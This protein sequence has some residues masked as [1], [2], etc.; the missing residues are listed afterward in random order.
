MAR[1]DEGD[2][3]VMM[4]HASHLWPFSGLVGV[5][6]LALLF[7]ANGYLSGGLMHRSGICRTCHPKTS[8]RGV[9]EKKADIE[10]IGAPKKS[11]CSPQQEVERADRVIRSL[12]N[13][14]FSKSSEPPF[15]I[16]QQALQTIALS[17][18]LLV[19]VRR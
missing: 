2:Y 19:S 10:K 1:T 9:G 16:L 15:K 17:P 6:L 18:Y 11:Q 8:L 12:V 5:V 13:G 7:S 3:A 4:G 14:T